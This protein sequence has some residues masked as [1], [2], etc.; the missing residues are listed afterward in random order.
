MKTKVQ[1][2]FRL[3]QETLDQLDTMVE[4]PPEW[5]LTIAPGPVKDR[6]DAVERLIFLAAKH[7]SFGQPASDRRSEADA[8]PV[9]D[10]RTAKYRKTAKR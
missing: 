8:K 6:T 4:S 2:A 3:Y 5:L 1:T 9:F 7:H 10:K